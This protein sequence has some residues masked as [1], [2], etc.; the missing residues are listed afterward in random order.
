MSNSQISVCRADDVPLNS[1]KRVE[2]GAKALAIYN[3]DGTFYATDDNCTHGM[4]S[5]AKGTLDGDVIECSLHFGA[6]HVPTGKPVGKPCSVALKT[7]QAT[8][9]DGQVLVNIGA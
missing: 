4:S 5:L 7:Y 1:V 8:V 3:V 2:V 9:V 6:F